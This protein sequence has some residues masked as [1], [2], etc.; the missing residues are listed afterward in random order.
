MNVEV[1]QAK[2]AKLF[3]SKPSNILSVFFTAGY[4]SLNDT[5]LIINNLYESGVD[6]VEVGIPFSDPLADGPVIQESSHK[7]LQNGMTLKLLFEQL[8]SVEA[9]IPLILMGYINPVLQFGIIPFCASCKKVSVEAVIL[10]D[11]PVEIYKDHYEEVFTK[12]GILP[13][14]L[15]TPQTSDKRIR[16]IDDQQCAFI[17]AV[18]S[19]STTGTKGWESGVTAYLQRLQSLNLRH[20]VITGF[21]IKDKKSFDAAC[22]YTHGAIIGSAF[23]KAISNGEDL[24]TSITS[25]MSTIR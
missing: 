12:Y 4:P 16:Y 10:P 6:M 3:R 7:A 23:I 25:F 1:K 20:P 8:K 15:V 21:N 17:Y 19:A 11:L 5:A 13:V 14:F 2:L 9:D 22:Q 24:K 18:S